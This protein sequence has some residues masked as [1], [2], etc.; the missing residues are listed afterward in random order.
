[1]LDHL[2]N[3]SHSADLIFGVLI[4]P[5]QYKT[6]YDIVVVVVTLIALL[7]VL[8]NGILLWVIVRDPC[9]QLRTNTA[10]LVGFNTFTNLLISFFVSLERI[11]I[12]TSRAGIFTPQLTVYLEACNA[13]MFFLGCFLHAF[14]CYGTIVMPLRYNRMAPR[15]PKTTTLII[16]LLWLVNA[17]VFTIIP[18]LLPSSRVLAYIQATVTLDCIILA[19]LTLTFVTLYSRIFWTLY[20]RKNRLHSFHLRRSSQGVS[21]L[22]QNTQVATTLCIHMSYLILVWTPGTIVFMLLLYCSSCNA[23]QVKLATLFLFPLL[24]SLFLFHPLLWLCRM[25]RYR[26]ALKKILG[27]NSRSNVVSC[28]T[29]VTVKYPTEETRL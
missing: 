4:V 10:I 1:M 7:G 23:K 14:N 26:R 19:L 22:K 11:L 5:K 29:P 17:C 24:Y 13:N 2:K 18:L 6:E 16:S 28:S 21:V 9:K 12:W 8:T 15:S 20:K 25:T 3:N 27:L